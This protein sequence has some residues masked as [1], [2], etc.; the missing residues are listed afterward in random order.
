MRL[1]TALLTVSA[2]LYF[3]APAFAALYEWTDKRGV[4]HITDQLK[5]VPPEYRDRMKVHEATAQNAEEAKPPA[6]PE[7]TEE[8]YGEYPLQWWLETFR[9]KKQDTQQLD[10]TILAKRQFIEIFERGRRL[11]QTYGTTE[12]EKY[13]LYKQ[14]LPDDER[15]LSE[16]QDEIEELKRKATIAGVPREIREQ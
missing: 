12:T 7:K 15:K 2:L 11:G 16:L 1:K 14:E 4:V 10:S 5:N 8:L 13:L 6:E 9:K 3:I